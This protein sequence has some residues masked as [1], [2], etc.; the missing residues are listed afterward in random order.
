M[1]I[2][3]R[4]LI[5]RECGNSRSLRE[6]AEEYWGGGLLGWRTV[7]AVEFAPFPAAVLCLRQNNG[8]LAPFPIWDDVRSFNGRPW[9]GR[10]DVVSG[11]FPCQDISPAGRKAGIDGERSGLWREFARII[12]EVRPPFAFVENSSDLRRRGLDRVL[13]DL[14]QIGYDA[15][16]RVLGADD[17]GAPHIRKRMWILAVDRDADVFGGRNGDVSDA[18]GDRRDARGLSRGTPPKIAVFGIRSQGD[19]LSDAARLGQHQLA[20]A[21]ASGNVAALRVRRGGIRVNADAVRVGSGRISRARDVAQAHSADVH[22]G[23]AQANPWRETESGVRRVVNGMAAGVDRAK[24]VAALGNGQIPLV[25][26]IAFT[27][28]YAVLRDASRA[29]VKR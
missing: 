13:G 18:Q 15:A 19:A 22:A 25:A 5:L 27:S 21:T 20:R 6:R 8:L 10:I 28:L 1:W 9:R 17:V 12:R 4:T 14:A 16:W 2:L 7:G 26:A 23:T 11:G 29:R 3:S 24:R